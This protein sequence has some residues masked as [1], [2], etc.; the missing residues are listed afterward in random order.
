MKPDSVSSEQAKPAT[1]TPQHDAP[2]TPASEPQAEPKRA[3]KI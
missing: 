3:Q 2:K 1:V